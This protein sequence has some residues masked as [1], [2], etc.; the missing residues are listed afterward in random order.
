MAVCLLRNVYEEIMYIITTSY[1]YNLDIDFM[2]KVG[3]FKNM[4]VD[5]CNELI[6]DIYTSEE[7][8]GIYSYLSK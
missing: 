4:V 8:K 5:N 3:Y 7:I 6:G 2:S 1:Y